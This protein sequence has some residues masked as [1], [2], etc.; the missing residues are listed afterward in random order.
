MD[1]KSLLILGV[2]ILVL[3]M[4]SKGINLLYPP[5]PVP[6]ASLTTNQ[7]ANPP[8]VQTSGTNVE[9]PVTGAPGN[10]LPAAPTNLPP[11][12]VTLS[13]SNKDLVFHFTS[14][15]GGLKEIA[16]RDTNYPAVV[17]ST[18]KAGDERNFATLDAGVTVPILA[19]LDG[20]EQGDGS[21]TLTQPSSNIVRAEKTLPGCLRVIK[22]FVIGDGGTIYLF[23]AKIRLEN[24]SSNALQIPRRHVVVGT[25]TAI[26]P[27]DDPTMLGVI[28]YNGSKQ[29]DISASWF[30]NY[31]GGCALLGSRPR[32][33]YE[34]GAS[35]VVWAA[36]HSQY[37]AF[38]A[39]PSQPAAGVVIHNL[40]LPPPDAGGV[41][42]S[43]RLTLTNTYEAYQTAFAYPATRLDPSQSVEQS[44]TFYAG[45][46]EYNGLARIGH[47][48][49]NNLDL[50]MGFT[51]FLGIFSFCSKFLLLSMNG[52]HDYLGLSYGLSIIAITVIIKLVFWPMTAASTRSQKRQQAIAPQLKAIAEKYKDDPLKKHQKTTALMKEHKISPLG[53]CLPVLI[54]IPVFF[55][56]YSMLRNA[57]ELRGIPFLWAPDLTLPDTVV[58]IAGFPINPLPLLMGASQL[59]QSHLTPPSPGMDPGQQ[60]IMRYMPLLFIAIFYRMSSGLNLYYTVSNLLTIAQTKITKMGPDPASSPAKPAA[61]APQKKK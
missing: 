55:G 43:Q 13:V 52:L 44:F 57:I 21:Y 42:A 41:A 2:A 4:L 36:M 61:P 34:E 33:E 23:A 60:K 56:F 7:T 51:G 53:S 12:E 14:Y 25:T 26:G 59:W 39:V 16:L 54:T 3:L 15:N 10:P 40:K 20:I 38:V 31:V 30:A 11:P 28:W 18:R 48:M 5:I 37:F 49:G 17:H 27:L 47:S 45:P 29:T 24:T 32:T 35:N 46:K 50:V 22:D 8:T 19:V 6:V 1:R 9:A 58:T